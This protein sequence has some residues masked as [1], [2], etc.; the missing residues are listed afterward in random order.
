MLSFNLI[1]NCEK[2]KSVWFWRISF[3]KIDFGGKFFLPQN[4]SCASMKISSKFEEEITKCTCVQC[5]KKV[6]IKSRNFSFM[7]QIRKMSKKT[8]IIKELLANK[9][10]FFLFSWETRKHS[11]KRWRRYETK[12]RH[13]VIRIYWN[14]KTWKLK[15]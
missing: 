4:F 10:F 12:I 11:C 1:W 5:E 3:N 8:K 7:F 9:D 14:V 2:G 6:G 15:Y 13:T